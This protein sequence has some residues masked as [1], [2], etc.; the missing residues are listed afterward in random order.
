VIDWFVPALVAALLWAGV[1]VADDHLLRNLYRAPSVAAGTA[2]CAAI[3][4]A[5]IVFALHRSISLDGTAVVLALLAGL[6]ATLY[7]YLLFRAF[8]R[9]EPSVVV[10]LGG[11]GQI[12]L[13]IAAAVTLAER[14]SPR[15][16]LGILIIAGGSSYLGMLDRRSSGFSARLVLL[17]S[18]GAALFVGI[19]LCL[20][21]A[22]ELDSF[23]SVFPWYGA[24][25]VIGGSSFLAAGAGSRLAP[26]VAAAGKRMLALIA[27]IEA[28]NGLADYLQGWAISRGP[29]SAVRAVEGSQ[30]LFVLVLGVILARVTGQVSRE[31]GTSVWAKATLFVSLIVGVVL[32]A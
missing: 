5:G 25:S 30:P 13:P 12:A 22:Y 24:G 28:V 2:G 8:A 10:A 32:V 3:I 16:Y 29:V 17:A 27:A 15:Q 11:L 9:H 1:N 14:L 19:S 18:V 20:K 4:P 26:A 21:R 7:V 23:P 31:R 6:G